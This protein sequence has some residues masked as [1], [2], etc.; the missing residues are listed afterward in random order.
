VGAKGKRNGLLGFLFVNSA[1]QKFYLPKLKTFHEMKEKLQTIFATLLLDFSVKIVMSISG[2]RSVCAKF[3][4]L[5][6]SISADINVWTLQWRQ[7][8]SI[9]AAHLGNTAI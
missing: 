5:F 8:F 2:Y 3:W 1:K 4:V 9:I 6:S 7:S